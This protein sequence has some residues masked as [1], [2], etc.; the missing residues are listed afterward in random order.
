MGGEVDDPDVLRSVSRTR[1]LI[2][3]EF[4]EL[5]GR[6]LKLI[7]T[8]HDL[9]QGEVA[10]R[11]GVSKSY[12][13]EI[14]NQNRTPSLEVIEAYSKAFDIPVSS[15]MLF[16]EELSSPTKERSMKALISR[17]VLKMLEFIDARAA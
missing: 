1:L 14:E 17:K 5:L 2:S 9:T 3:L 6:A 8:F 10:E 16:S 11:V 15:I 13:S 12:I 7:R 4:L